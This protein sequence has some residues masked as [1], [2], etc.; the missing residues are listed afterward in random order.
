MP[1]EHAEEREP[2]RR[3]RVLDRVER[4]RVE[5]TQ[6]A[7]QEPDPG[8]GEDAPHVEAVGPVEP[9]GLEQRRRNH[10][11]QREEDAARGNDEERDL[12]QPGLEACAQVRVAL[13][14]SV[15]DARTA[16]DIAGSSAAETDMPNRLT[17]ST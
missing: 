5:P 8:A 4:R 14:C 16:P 12:P 6:G 15:D 10:L 13:S 1:R 9:S 7:G 17:G 11:P 3:P 2:H